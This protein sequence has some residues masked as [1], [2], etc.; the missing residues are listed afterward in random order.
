MTTDEAPGESWAIHA[1][2]ITAIRGDGTPDNT[3]LTIVDPAGGR[4]YRESIATFVPKYEEEVIRTGKMRVQVV[5]WSADARA[6]V[7]AQSF[8][9]RRRAPQRHS[10]QLTKQDCPPRR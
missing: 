5:H 10:R 4:Q 7:R 3:M 2:V 6:E 1:R 9:R 8:G